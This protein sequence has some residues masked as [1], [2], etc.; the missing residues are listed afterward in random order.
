MD[1]ASQ[2]SCF[3]SFHQSLWLGKTCSLVSW[4]VICVPSQ[5]HG[6]VTWFS[7]RCNTR[8]R[9]STNAVT[10][11]GNSRGGLS[12]VSICSSIRAR[13]VFSVNCA[14]RSFR[15]GITSS[16]IRLCTLEPNHS[17]VPYVWKG[18]L[19][20]GALRLICLCILEDRTTLAIFAV[21]HFTPTRDCHVTGNC[22][23]LKCKLFEGQTLLTFFSD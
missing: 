20:K 13:G 22:I 14:N 16:D 2:M 1:T 3:H 5:R 8:T 17:S 4:C 12:S 10:A 11:S 6:R 21:L 15:E 19:K 23:C 7:I 9:K 18:S